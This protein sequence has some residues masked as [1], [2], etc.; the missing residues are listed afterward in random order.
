M[1]AYKTEERVVTP[2]QQS[3]QTVLAVRK[4]LKPSKAHFRWSQ[5]V[6]LLLKGAAVERLCPACLCCLAARGLLE[7]FDLAAGGLGSLLPASFP[8]ARGGRVHKQQLQSV[9]GSPAGPLGRLGAWL[10]PHWP[11]KGCSRTDQE[12]PCAKRSQ[13]SGSAGT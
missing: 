5:R 3:F 2:N 13:I 11:S 1:E 8:P 4:D 10:R 7:L 9:I 6:L 12:P